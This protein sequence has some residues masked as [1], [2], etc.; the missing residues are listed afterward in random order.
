MSRIFYYLFC[1]FYFVFVAGISISNSVYFSNIYNNGTIPSK[2]T[3]TWLI[4]LNAFLVVVSVILIIITIYMHIHQH[5]ADS[6]KLADAH[7]ELLN[8]I[9]SES[10]RKHHRKHHRSVRH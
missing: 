4:I 7:T 2:N 1:I 9:T 10:H 8:K 3:M 6:E 5:F